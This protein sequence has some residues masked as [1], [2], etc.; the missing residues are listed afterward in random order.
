M[1]IDIVH[2]TEIL[3]GFFVSTLT[4][5]GVLVTVLSKS[6][7]QSFNNLEELYEKIEKRMLITEQELETS[8]AENIRLESL[9]NEY[10]NSQETMQRRMVILDDEKRNLEK[11]Y[12]EREKEIKQLLSEKNKEIEALK[13]D[14][15]KLNQKVRL[16]E[17]G[18]AP[19]P[20]RKG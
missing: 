13:S 15:F 18:T 14:V 9:I 4:A 19:L 12:Q 8:K 10:K 5:V 17:R 1:Q 6:D 7:R 16:L 2:L 3:V 20:P 11:K